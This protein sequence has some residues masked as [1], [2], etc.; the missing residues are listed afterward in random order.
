MLTIY[1]DYYTQFTCTADSCPIRSGRSM[2]M[3]Q[4]SITGKHSLRLTL[5][6]QIAESFL[7]ISQKK[8]GKM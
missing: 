2:W 8:K 7:P 4:Q 1:P 3:I 6:M 5:W